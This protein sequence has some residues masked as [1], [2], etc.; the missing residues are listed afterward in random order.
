MAGNILTSLAVW[1]DFE[2]SQI[3]VAH[4]IDEKRV[5][6]VILSKVYLDGRITDSGQVKI[7][8]V[9]ARKIQLGV[10]PAVI[11]YNDFTDDDGVALAL[12]LAKK[13]YMAFAVDLG[14]KADGKE[15]FTI[16][17][18]DLSYANYQENKDNILNIETDVTATCWYEWGV[19][20][21]YALKYLSNQVCVTKVGAIATGFACTPVWQLASTESELACSAFIMN[22][23]WRAYK[24]LYKFG[25]QLEPQYSDD[26]LKF[27][28]GVEPQSYAQNVKSPVLLLS[29][30]NSNEY[31]CD[32]AYDTVD[33][34]ADGVYRAVYY[35]SAFTNGVDENGFKN[36]QI[37]LSEF[38]AK[39]SVN[40]KNLPAEPMLKCEAVEGNLVAEVTVDLNDLK[41]VWLYY[42]Q[43]TVN[44]AL[45]VWSKIL[46]ENPKKNKFSFNLTIPGEQI[47]LFAQV[48]YKS[49]FTQS[50]NILFRKLPN[51]N[52][53]PYKQKIV[54][55]GRNSKSTEVFL[56]CKD[57][58]KN[59]IKYL[60][61]D[62]KGGVLEK[63]GPM[64]IKG[65]Y[66]AYG[67]RTYKINANLDKPSDD[68]LFMLDAFVKEDC[69]ISVSLITGCGENEV[70]YT[71][72]AQVKGGK[73]WHNLKFEASKFKTEEGRLLKSFAPVNAIEI[74]ATGEYLINN[75]LWV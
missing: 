11:I 34:I 74:H 70:Y 7:Y 54:F 55:N 19:A 64:D 28:A 49:G 71:A 68:A 15:N 46:G 10:M 17:P 3:P 36:L 72:R 21:R 23:G 58:A 67:L 59:P 33:R 26:M 42:S 63:N 5:G 8:G 73:V 25:G 40:G 47:S 62:V 60:E 12:D 75:V 14:G 48:K 38:L 56:S 1:A 69:E 16:Y 30:L 27:I 37:F 32:R 44:P 51:I 45:R 31:D 41:E 20:A 35:S 22:A 2:V 6:D 57:T 53:C 39:E 66:C 18:D 61:T 9:L 29:A 50:T 24:G 43:E 52:V 13:G 65:V 4:V